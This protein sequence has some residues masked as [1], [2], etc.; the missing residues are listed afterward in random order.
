MNS[1]K[2]KNLFFGIII[3]LCTFVCG[4]A[5]FPTATV[6]EAKAVDENIPTYF[7]A[8]VKDSEDADVKAY[9]SGD[10]IL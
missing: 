1:T 9:Q 10:T 2:I 8:V 3:A 4:I 6:Q 5:I 7:S